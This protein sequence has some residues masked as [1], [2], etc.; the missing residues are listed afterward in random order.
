MSFENYIQSYKR[1]ALSLASSTEHNAVEI[2]P[3]RVHIHS[4]F[5]FTVQSSIARM[6]YN[7]VYSFTSWLNFLL[8]LLLLI[9]L[10]KYLQLQAELHA[11]LHMLKL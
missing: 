10:R 11:P 1:A 3:G 7:L 8:F 4:S 5:L 6:C 2:L 9:E